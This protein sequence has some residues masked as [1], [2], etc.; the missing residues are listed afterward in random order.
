MSPLENYRLGITRSATH[1]PIFQAF[2]DYR[3][4]MRKK[5]QMGDCELE[6]LSFHASKV[7]YDIC[8]D[9][10]D[11]AGLDGVDCTLNL[12]VRQDM[13]SEHEARVLVQCVASLA[14]SSSYSSPEVAFG[15][16]DMFQKHEIDRALEL[17]TGPFLLSQCE[18]ETIV[19]LIRDVAA[20]K[21]DAPALKVAGGGIGKHNDNQP[22]SYREMDGRVPRHRR[23][24]AG[25][26][27]QQGLR[28]GDVR[29]RSAPRTG[30][31]PS[32]AS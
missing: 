16:T 32:S 14:E 19:H 25:P 27:V 11:D 5:Q 31:H 17:G 26:R 6:L 3:Q 9:I 7:P 29:A 21:P 1:T 4:G 24:P 23:C 8:L 28:R 18:P 12:I 13:Y 15:D 2:F 30:Y 10:I 20:A 22:V